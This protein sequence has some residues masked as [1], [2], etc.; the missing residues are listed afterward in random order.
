MMRFKAPTTLCLSGVTQS[1]KTTWLK[2]LIANKNQM[3]DPPPK[4]IKYCYG[5]WQEAFKDMK[6]LIFHK[7]LPTSDEIEDFADGSHCLLILDD[8]MDS[9]AKSEEAQRLFVR[10]SHH[11]NITVVYITQNMFYQ[12]KCARTIS[13]NCHYLVL[14]RNPRDFTQIQFLGRQIGLSKTLPEAYEDCMKEPFGYLVV[15]LH[16][17]S[18]EG[19]TLLTHVF[20]C[21]NEVVY[22]PL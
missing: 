11:K 19:P 6:N 16:P 5:V 8:L 7:D 3:F 4:K 1:G 22:K 14:F 17:H 15:D 9:V 13:L 21:E 12:G 2:K 10:G 18:T 20:P